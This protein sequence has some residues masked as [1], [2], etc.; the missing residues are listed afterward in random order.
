MGTKFCKLN[1]MEVD[2]WIM[3]NA[4]ETKFFELYLQ[5]Q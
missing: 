1:N 3:S 2:K 5:T 4:K